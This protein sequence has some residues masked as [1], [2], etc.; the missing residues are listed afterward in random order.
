MFPE[1]RRLHEELNA[2]SRIA[3]KEIYV[4]IVVNVVWI[5]STMV[6][7]YAAF[8]RVDAHRIGHFV[9]PFKYSVGR[10]DGADG[11]HRRVTETLV[12]SISAQI[13]L[14]APVC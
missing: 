6:T 12:D 14:E 13:V 4:I 7:H 8:S 3:V 11:C 10:S 9:E 1:R 5:G 2:F